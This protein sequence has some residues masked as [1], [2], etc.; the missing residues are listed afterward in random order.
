MKAG[1]KNIL[2]FSTLLIL[3]TAEN[4][5][6]AQKA[7][8]DSGFN[9]I[10]TLEKITVSTT[11]TEKSIGDIPVPIQVITKKFIQQTGSQKLIDILQQQT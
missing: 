2:F 10:A 5:V 4:A 1:K 8:T 7:A 9:S 6:L 3:L 11:R